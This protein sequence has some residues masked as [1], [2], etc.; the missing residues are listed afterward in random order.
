MLV[1]LG[2]EIDAATA[3]RSIP[4]EDKH[5]RY[6]V[7][8]IGG[9][10]NDEVIPRSA[11]LVYPPPTDKKYQVSGEHC[12]S[13]PLEPILDFFFEP[14]KLGMEKEGEMIPLLG[15]SQAR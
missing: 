13:A 3:Y 15:M 2:W 4:E 9:D 8:A 1:A 6:A 7:S 12:S 14:K 5:F 11:A 10:Y